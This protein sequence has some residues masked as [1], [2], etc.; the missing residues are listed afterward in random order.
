M[1]T[2]CPDTVILYAAQAEPVWQAIQREGA[3][4]SKAEYVRKK[5]AE[6]APVFLTAYDWFVRQLPRFVPKPD[7]AEFPYWAFTDLYMI[8]TG[9]YA[10][11]LTLEVPVEEAVFF[12][13][14][15]WNRILRMEYLGNTPAETSRFRQ[16]LKMRGLRDADVMLTQ[17]YPEFREQT[18]ASW[19]HLFRHQE[20]IL[21]GEKP[22]SGLQAGLWCLKKEWILRDNGVDVERSF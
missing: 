22:L 11:I 20:A 4:Y 5:Y 13:M 19:Q 21:R 18:I 2:K 8:E 12:E 3:A 6:S 10:H 14:D 1:G 15:D 7:G 17:F 16:E 9:A